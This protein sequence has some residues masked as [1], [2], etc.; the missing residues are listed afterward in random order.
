[1]HMQT[2]ITPRRLTSHDQHKY[3]HINIYTAL[4]PE[5]LRQRVVQ[6]AGELQ[7]RTKWEVKKTYK[8]VSICV[9]RYVCL[10]VCVCID[11]CVYVCVREQLQERTK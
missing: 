5:A 3:T 6:L 2:Y 10:Y 8:H 7:E 11:M 4:G 1:M 9:C